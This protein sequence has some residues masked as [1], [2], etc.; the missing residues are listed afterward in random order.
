M[1]F[2][3]CFKNAFE[4]VIHSKIRSWLTI[5][6]I[7]IGV[8]AVIAIM[9]LGSSMQQT[10]TRQL[11]GLGADILTVT[12]GT[13]RAVGTFAMRG[14]GGGGGRGTT[15]QSSITELSTSSFDTKLTHKDVQVLRTIPNINVV[16]TNIQGT[17][18]IEYLGKSG[19]IS[20]IGVDQST[21]NR[22]T[23]VRIREGRLLDSA[24]SNVIVIGGRLA[25]SFF[26]S[27]IRLN[28]MLTVDDRSLRVVGI[29]DDTS[30]NIYVP[31]NIA[32]ELLDD[33]ERGTYDRII[34]KIHD[35]EKIN[36]TIEEINQKLTIAR[37]VTSSNRDFSVSANIQTQ[38]TRNEMMKAIS[39]FLLAIATVSLIVG[40]IGIANTMF[41]A[42]LE[43][44]KDIG[45]MKAIGAKNKDILQIFLLNAAIIGLIGGI[46]GIFL[47][48]L[49]SN[50]LPALTS[51]I[52][53][54]SGETTIS[55]YSI[56]FA[57]SVST[58]IGVISGL[59]PAYKASRLKPADALRHG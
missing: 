37:M 34:I 26:D 9:S 55:L 32:Y 39:T 46:L 51:E 22:I 47:G 35:Q 6:G 57:L 45:I 18:R 28:H 52:R 36:E 54:I 10:V 21:W 19:S 59:I 24:D 13:Q 20:L 48:M 17:V 1:K 42:V 30:T 16:D 40:G 49:L 53:F 25:D 2:I 11:D 3:T 58:I 14:S 15:D 29:I 5:L 38:E 4:M 50:A 12:A 7:I 43:K 44:T 8:G 33:K 23:N 31:I 56:I 41:T 27:Q